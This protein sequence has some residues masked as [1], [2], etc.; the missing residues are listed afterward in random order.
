MTEFYA[1]QGLGN[2]LWVY[3]ACRSI[4]E[5]LNLPYKIINFEKFKGHDFLD[6]DSGASN[7]QVYDL[8]SERQVRNFHEQ[9]FFDPDL[10][11]IASDFD[12]SV[13]DLR[14]GTKIHGLFQSEKYFFGDLK[15]PRQYLKL[16]PESKA[17]DIVDDDCCVVCIR[18]GEYKRHKNLILPKSYWENAIQNMK[19]VYGIKKFIAITDDER[20][21][22][23]ILPDLKLLSGGGVGGDYLALYQARF[24]IIA[25]SSFAYFPLKTGIH[26]KT[27]IAPLHWAR[28][29]NKYSRWASPANLYS[30]W[31]W[32]DSMG[33]LHTSLDCLVSRERTIEY[34]KEYYYISTLPS[35]VANYGF[36][37]YL[38]VRFK[39]TVKAGLAVILPR[40]IG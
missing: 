24:A 16:K 22:R 27:V 30:D 38:P 15:R 4:A 32:Q 20:Y 13:L 21:V 40:W 8:T 36:R 6:L 7:A 26:K 29:N 17:K 37:K 10:K 1:G 5:Q 39:Q 18:G 3:V 9:N 28:F 2:Q 33:S 23:S 11:Y 19:T 35:T 12:A 34:Y 25:N 14:P 31:I